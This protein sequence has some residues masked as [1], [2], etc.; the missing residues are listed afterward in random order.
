[1]LTSK[2]DDSG[3]LKEIVQENRIGLEQGLIAS[4]NAFA[5]MR[6]ASYFS[7]LA[8]YRER[9]NGLTYYQFLNDLEKNF[10]DRSQELTE[11]LQ[12]TARLI[13]N[14]NAML[15]SVTVP[16]PEF[17]GLESNF[18]A[19][20]QKVPAF[21][22]VKQPFAFQA[23][24][25]NE[26]VVIPS[27]VQYVVRAA[28]FKAAGGTYSGKMNVLTNILRTGYLWNNIRVQGGAYG[29]GFSVDR[30]GLFSFMSY[31][32]PHLQR[33]V[34]VFDGTAE[35]LAG[36]EMSDLDL[37]KAIIATSGSM[38]RP[39]T[40][41]EKGSRAATRYIVGISQAEIQRERD[42]VLATTVED[43][44]SFSVIL[45]KAM[46]QNNICVFGNENKINESRELFKNVIRINP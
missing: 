18:E 13:F 19:F 27:Q 30:T 24:Q 42:E 17:K 6:A 33:T 15:V 4:G 14:R 39:T 35:F 29:S 5:Q 2:F 34:D 10:D 31:R 43:L 28:D 21:E 12:E 41:A 32:D 40:P 16:E 38:D 3:R 25:S 1:M 36:L 44:R 45:D 46:K 26:A 9:I 8:A 20:T 23:Y 37:T 7:P 22:Y 11:K